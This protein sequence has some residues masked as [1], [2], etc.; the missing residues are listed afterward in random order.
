M[1]Q[2]EFVCGILS[3]ASALSVNAFH[4]IGG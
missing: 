2:Y 1:E 3:L 4:L